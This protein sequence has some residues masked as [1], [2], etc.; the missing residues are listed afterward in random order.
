MLSVIND[1]SALEVFNKMIYAHNGN[2]NH[3]HFQANPNRQ[4]G[5][6]KRHNRYIEAAS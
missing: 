1:G 2:I 5:S 3:I 4:K 6:V